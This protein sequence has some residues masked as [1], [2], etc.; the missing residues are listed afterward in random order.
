MGVF[1][2]IGRRYR[3]FKR[4]NQII[5]VFVKYGFEDMVS[6]LIES[7]NFRWVRRLIPRTTRKRAELHS[8]WEKMR[9][10]C[11][12]LGPTFVKFGQILSNRP[13]LLP[14]ELTKEFEKLQDR[15]PPFATELARKVVETELKKACEILFTTFEPQAFA[16]A[17]MAQVHKAQLNTGELVAVKIQRPNIRA[18]IIEDIRVMYTLAVILEKR[19][20]SLKAFDPVGLVKNFEEGIMKELDFIHESINIQRFYSDLEGDKDNDSR[21]PKVFQEMTTD[22]VLTMEF[23]KGTKVSDMETLLQKGHDR[24]KIADKLAHA[25]IKQVF[26]YGF[27]HA[28][29]HPGNIL[30]MSDGELCFLDFGLMG[31]IMERDIE[32]FGR[33]F[34]AVKDKD[35]KKIIRSLQQLSG[36]FTVKD[37]RA[38]EYA[39]NDFVHSYS[40]T[41]VHQ[42]EM[43]NVLNSLKE[44]IVEHGLRVPSHFFLL[45]KSMVTVE[46]VIHTLDPDLDLLVL[47]RP[48][49][50]RI[51]AKKL[52]P[53]DWGK[54]IFN[55]LY[56]FGVHM[57][58]FPRDLKNA[59]RRINTGQI[60]VNLN[61]KGIDPIVH[62]VNRVTKQIVSAV[63]VAGLLVGSILL[64]IN[65]I[66]PMWRGYSAFGLIGVLLAMVTVLG[67]IR[68]IWKG[69]HDDW[70]GW[71][72]K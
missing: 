29:L 31:S 46:G 20:P 57:E 35:V 15:V 53:L 48:Y 7:S 64:I 49:M 9:L 67:M 44:I 22:K 45:A 12:E 58:D 40:A 6:Y 5:R 66:G 17:S 10:V 69:D 60:S 18:I 59:V 36:D 24:K 16:S 30:V 21:C 26:Q 47:A 3:S 28:D 32:M 62:T 11:E 14:F 1:S 8:K 68:N 56:E 51:V 72:E 41:S 27:F 50:K 70:R 34:I 55:T 54:K 65:H 61:H 4:Y 23:V 63:L 43:S 39:I 2:S 19:I 33:L 13:D 71:Q 37:M 25:Y 38:F 52:N 42:N